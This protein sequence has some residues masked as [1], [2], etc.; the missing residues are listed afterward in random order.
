M[1]VREVRNISP[2]NFT[3]KMLQDFFRLEGA[4]FN[5][6]S[7]EY[8][9]GE[10]I[11]WGKGVEGGDAIQI[12]LYKE[13]FNARKEKLFKKKLPTIMI[14]VGKWATCRYGLTDSENNLTL[15]VERI[16][17]IDFPLVLLGKRYITSIKF[18]G[19]SGGREVILYLKSNGE[20]SFISKPS[21][22]KTKIP[23]V[24]EEVEKLKG[25]RL[26]LEESRKKLEELSKKM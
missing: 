19:T 21:K 4:S 17:K 25:E 12:T 26:T 22:R 7:S 13:V 9:S 8:G 3:L 1:G 14:E 20:I 2:K 16:E 11:Y 15:A 6:S 5:C 24:R 10:A 23:D 18:M